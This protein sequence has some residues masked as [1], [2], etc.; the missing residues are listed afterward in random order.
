MQLVLVL[1]LIFALLVAI[2]AL[3]NANEV[4]IRF[5]WGDYPVSQAIVILGSA[6]IG[7]VVIMILGIF[8]QIKSKIKIWEYQGKIKKLEKELEEVKKQ[9]ETLRIA[10]EDQSAEDI[11]DKGIPRDADV[12]S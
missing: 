6:A 9:Y 10:M 12:S 7:S 8:S 3:S 11:D 4:I 1:T 5:P 2:F